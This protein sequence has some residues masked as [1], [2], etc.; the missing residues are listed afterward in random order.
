MYDN[1]YGYDQI[2]VGPSLDTYAEYSSSII[3]PGDPLNSKFNH[4]QRNHIGENYLKR[5]IDQNINKEKYINKSLDNI[6]QLKNMEEMTEGEKLRKFRDIYDYLE[7]NA[8]PNPSRKQYRHVQQDDYE[9][10]YKNREIEELKKKLADFQYKN[11]IFL[12]FIICLIVYIM[13]QTNAVKG[14]TPMMLYMNG[15]PSS[16][17]G[18]PVA[19]V[20]PVPMYMPSAPIV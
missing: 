12:L 14:S 8:D 2:N 19:S 13:M 7:Y 16:P 20:T 17:M 3:K 5:S 6:Q 15:M 10:Q 9:T 4:V 11:D 1:G 18:T